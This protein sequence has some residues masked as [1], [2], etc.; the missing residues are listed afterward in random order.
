MWYGYLLFTLEATYGELNSEANRL[1]FI[2][3]IDVVH[4]IQG[5]KKMIHFSIG[6]ICVNPE[7]TTKPNISLDT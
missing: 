4:L 2:T 3:I 1:V 6:N 7:D 5:A